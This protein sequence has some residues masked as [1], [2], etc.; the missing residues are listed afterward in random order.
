M[1]LS[2]ILM[3]SLII[4]LIACTWHS[5]PCI[6]SRHI[7]GKIARKYFMLIN[8]AS[9][10]LVWIDKILKQF[11]TS[12]I[13]ISSKQ[14]AV[15]ATSFP[16]PFPSLSSRRGKETGSGKEVAVQTSQTTYV[17]INSCSLAILVY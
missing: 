11:M 17:I 15:Q 10:N 14:S 2:N 9:I 7:L 8:Q 1:Q 12:P 4:R 13:T 6:S 3:Q 5:A 16:G